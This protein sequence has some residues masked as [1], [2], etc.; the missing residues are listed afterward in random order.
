MTLIPRGCL[1]TT[2]ITVGLA[3][4]FFLVYQD[5]ALLLDS[6][7]STNSVNFLMEIK[8]HMTGNEAY[9]EIYRAIWGVYPDHHSND[10]N[11]RWT[12]SYVDVGARRNK[13]KTPSI[14]TGGVDTT[15]NSRH[16]HLIIN[17]DLHSDQNTGT[18]EQI[19]KVKTHYRLQDPLLNP[20]CPTVIIGT[21]WTDDDL[22]S[23][24]MEEHA[25]DFNFI[26]RSAKSPSGELLYPS[27]LDEEELQ[28]KRKELGGSLS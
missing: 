23:M 2:T 14:D 25:D 13:D 15:K 1:K 9:R 7:T 28:A 5:E 10:K 22:Y 17:D 21:R 3:L 19:E 11:W 4:Q 26:V 6:E 20:G 16:Y 8:G 18:K 27:R 24:I 12:N